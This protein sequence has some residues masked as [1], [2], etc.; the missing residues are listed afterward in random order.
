MVRVKE[1]ECIAGVVCDRLVFLMISQTML[2]SRS[3]RMLNEV[4]V[5]GREKRELL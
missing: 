1:S 5:E 4:C 3:L 2:S